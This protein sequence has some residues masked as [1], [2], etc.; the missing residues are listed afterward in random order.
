MSLTELAIAW[1]LR[2][3]NVASALT[4]AS[5]PQQIEETVKAVYKQIPEEVLIEIENVLLK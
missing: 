4:G 5:T 3:K 1:V 2:Q